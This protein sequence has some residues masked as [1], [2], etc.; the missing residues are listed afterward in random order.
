MTFTILCTIRTSSYWGCG[1]VSFYF[2]RLHSMQAVWACSVV[3]YSPYWWWSLTA[4]SVEDWKRNVSPNN[5]IL[6][7]VELYCWPLYSCTQY[8]LPVAQKGNSWADHDRIGAMFLYCFYVYM[9]LRLFILDVVIF[10][11]HNKFYTYI[12]SLYPID[13]LQATS[14]M[15]LQAKLAVILTRCKT[16]RILL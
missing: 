11:A 2:N 8:H 15:K 13:L 16:I 4:T 1:R 9:K 12:K 7:S 3:L 10:M 14:T 5:Y 6:I